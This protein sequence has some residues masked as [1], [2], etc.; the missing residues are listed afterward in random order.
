MNVST[1]FPEGFTEN[2]RPQRHASASVKDDEEV[3]DR[4]NRKYLQ[5][6]ILSAIVIHIWIF[7]VIPFVTLRSIVRYI[8]YQA[9][10]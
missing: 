9:I 5:I 1:V 3:Q 4:Y 7:W 8:I 10:P 2:E 6:L